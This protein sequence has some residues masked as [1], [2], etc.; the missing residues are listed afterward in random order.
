MGSGTSQW[1]AAAEE[2]GEAKHAMCNENDKEGEA[3]AKEEM[4][5]GKACLA[6]VSGVAME[7]CRLEQA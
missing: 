7:A 3:R 5:K 1:A 4:C 6:A 2:Q